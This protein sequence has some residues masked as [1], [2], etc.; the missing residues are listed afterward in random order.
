MPRVNTKDVEDA[1][2]VEGGEQAFVAVQKFLNQVR[3]SSENEGSVDVTLSQTTSRKGHTRAENDSVGDFAFDMQT[4]VDELANEIVDAAVEDC[5]GLRARVMKYHVKVAGMSPRAVFTLK[6]D[7]GTEQEMDDVEDL[8]NRKGLLGLFMRHN[9]G[10]HK[11]SIGTSRHLIDSL[12][13]QLDKKE[14]TILKLQANA[15]ENIKAFEE[16]V[17]GRHM[18]DMEMRKVENKDRRMDQ[19][20]GTVLTGFPLLVSKFLGGGAGAAAM[21]SV[22]GART[23]METLLEGFVKTLDPEQFNN[24]VSSGIFRPEQ[25]AML[26]EVVKFMMERDE[27]EK[28]KSAKESNGSGKTPGPQPQEPGAGA[29]T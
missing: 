13:A 26:V 24:I 15:M 29:S 8:P 5:E 2:F 9:E 17:S 16:L 3:R 20:A 11:L 22:P 4:D 14:E 28:D 18:R 6:G 19:L 27:A 12:M 23:P 25:V 7:D 21:A 1:S 10:Q